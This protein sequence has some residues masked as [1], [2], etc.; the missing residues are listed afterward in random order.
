MTKETI[1][2]ITDAVIEA[3]DDWAVRALDETW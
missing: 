3:M 2:R 1:S